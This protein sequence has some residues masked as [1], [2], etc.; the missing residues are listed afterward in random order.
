MGSGREARPLYKL[1]VSPCS[2]V[3]LSLSLAAHCSIVFAVVFAVVSKRVRPVS[4]Y[5]QS[6]AIRAEPQACLCIRVFS[7]PSPHHTNGASWPVA[8]GN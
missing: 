5:K 6:E 3:P 8:G 7:N 2:P 4:V 1:C